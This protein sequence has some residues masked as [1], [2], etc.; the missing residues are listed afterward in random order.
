[1][2]NEYKNIGHKEAIEPFLYDSQ[3]L[4]ILDP[5]YLNTN[6]GYSNNIYVSQQNKEHENMCEYIYDLFINDSYKCRAILV[7]NDIFYMR[8]LF[9]KFIVSSHDI[10]YMAHA[11]R[12]TTHIIC[13]K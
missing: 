2:N 9:N 1:M 10:N 7:V 6:N 8:I 5:P 12:K 3:C 11:K 13:V 4:I